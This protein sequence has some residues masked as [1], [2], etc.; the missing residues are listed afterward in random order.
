MSE[1]WIPDKGCD[2][3]VCSTINNL[4]DENKRLRELLFMGWSENKIEIALKENNDE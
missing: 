2:C 3:P 1:K 4:Q